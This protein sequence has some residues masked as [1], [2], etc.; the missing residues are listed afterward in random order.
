MKKMI[1]TFVIVTVAVTTAL[2]CTK[3][4]IEM[5]GEGRT[6]RF[7]SAASETKTVFGDKNAETGK[8]PVLW[9]DNQKVALFYNSQT[10]GLTGSENGAQYV[11][12]VPSQDRL[13]AEFSA[14]FTEETTDSHSFYAFSPLCALNWRGDEDWGT[15]IKKALY[16]IIPHDQVPVPGTCDEK[17]QLIVAHKEYGAFPEK[18]ELSFSHLSSYGRIKEL[19]LPEGATEI[20]DVKIESNKILSGEIYYYY[21]EPGKVNA[22]YQ[23]EEDLYKKVFPY[24]SLD[25]NNAPRGTS[26]KDV[27][28]ATVPVSFGEG[29]WLKIKVHTISDTWVKTINFTSDKPLEFKPG[30]ISSFNVS[31][32]GF[33]TI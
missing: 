22:N 9:T 7:T 26:L 18:V 8:Y 10:G 19:S 30:Q 23:K 31:A 14:T 15:V 28:F 27:F 5:S 3:S 16:A 13:T 11:T 2:S 1:E 17:A 24:I 6:V 29:D 20:V 21:D 12:P 33:A 25:V 32:E 4:N